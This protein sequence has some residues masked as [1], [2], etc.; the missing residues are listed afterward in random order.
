MTYKNGTEKRV[1][2]QFYFLMYSPPL[3][4]L[5][6]ISFES[7]WEQARSICSINAFRLRNGFFSIFCITA[8]PPYLRKHVSYFGSMFGK[9]SQC[10]ELYHLADMPIFLSQKA[11]SPQKKVDS[12]TI[13]F[14]PGFDGKWCHKTILSTFRATDFQVKSRGTK[15]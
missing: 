4:T 9:F 8:L 15:I 1:N 14:N 13:F 11:G 10:V 3:T 6:L 12:F 2:V 7:T 5:F